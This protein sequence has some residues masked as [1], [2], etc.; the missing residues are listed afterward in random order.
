MLYQF[1]LLFV[2]NRLSRLFS[3]LVNDAFAEFSYDASLAGL[4]Y[5]FASHSLGTFITVN[6]YN[7]KLPVLMKHLL[8]KIKGLQVKQE[9]LHVMKEQVRLLPK[10]RSPFLTALS[11]TS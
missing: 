5:N 10:S 4:S 6:G 7:D 8:E 1:Q 3:D 2:A 11:L 9:R